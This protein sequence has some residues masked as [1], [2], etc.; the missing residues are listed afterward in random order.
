MRIGFYGGIANNTYVA[1]KSCASLGH[2]VLFIRDIFDL[3][4]FSQPVWEDLSFTLPYEKI[5]LNNFTLSDWR[6]F[7]KEHN[8]IRPSWYIEPSDRFTLNNKDITLNLLSPL[9]AILLKLYI[10]KEPHRLHV[11]KLMKSCDTLFVCG[12]EAEILAWFSGVP[13][14]IWP[15]G[16]DSRMAA[17]LTPPSTK[18]L[19]QLIRHFAQYFFLRKSFKDAL[20]I[21]S[22]SP[23]GGGGHIGKVPFCQE[24]L[25]IPLPS[26]TNRKSIKDRHKDLIDTCKKV[27]IVL[28]KANFYIFVP[29]RLD[30]FWK[31]T[32]RLLNAI[33]RLGH[34]LDGK[35]H[36]IFSG[37]GS[38]YQDAKMY[39]SPKNSTF[40]PC[41]VSK[42]I[43]FEFFNSV[44]IVIDQF[45]LGCYGTAAAEAMSCATP[46]MMYIDNHS[47][48]SLGWPAPPVLNAQ[49][50]DEIFLTLNELV[51]EKIDLN[52]ISEQ[53]S[54]WFSKTH[55]ENVVIPKFIQDLNNRGIE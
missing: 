13:Y 24:Y 32:D 41:A 36:F 45:I 44:D 25:P 43:L 55:D 3:Y 34:K 48:N 33:N 15:H 19:H 30:F 20:W 54:L 42:P 49:T 1:A 31:G 16:G 52:A 14:V 12:I 2:D 4:P 23:K 22:H 29:S 38:N 21:G 39:V 11:I 37:W 27:G 8:W 35:I 6:L 7:E 53:V 40:L 18:N 51:E 28:P 5:V 50:E 10:K 17:G 47:F 26:Y 9:K 46:V